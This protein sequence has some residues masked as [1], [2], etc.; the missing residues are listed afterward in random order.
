MWYITDL[1]DKILESEAAQRIIDYVSDVYGE[2]YVGL[3][4]FQVIGI[5]IDDINTIIMGLF[6]EI[7]PETSEKLLP[8]WEKE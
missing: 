5:V 3:W 2:S 1:M 8:Y 7:F 6:D 4:L